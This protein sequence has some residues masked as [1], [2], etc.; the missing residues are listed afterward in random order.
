M[1]PLYKLWQ[2]TIRYGI[3]HIDGMDSMKSSFNVIGKDESEALQNVR[4]LF[5]QQEGGKEL[6]ENGKYESKEVTFDNYRERVKECRRTIPLPEISG[7]D[8]EKFK[9]TPRISDDGRNI[10]YIVSEILKE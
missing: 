9:L 5:S 3:H 8:A 1:K 6:I 10:E 4:N 2:V 7:P